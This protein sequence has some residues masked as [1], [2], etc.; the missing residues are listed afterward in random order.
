MLLTKVRWSFVHAERPESYAR[1]AGT[2]F[3]CTVLFEVET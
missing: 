2:A 3:A 1:R